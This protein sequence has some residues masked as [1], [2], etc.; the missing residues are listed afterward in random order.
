MKSLLRGCKLNLTS[1][2]NL[3]LSQNSYKATKH[4]EGLLKKK[5]K[6]RAKDYKGKSLLEILVTQRKLR[7]Q[8]PFLEIFE[9][10]EPQHY[11]KD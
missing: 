6:K 1:L 11:H 3:S 8:R 9:L 2:G 4:T 5:K 10:G 7:Q